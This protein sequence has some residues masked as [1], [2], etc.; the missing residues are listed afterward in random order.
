MR[1]RAEA[2]YGAM[3]RTVQRFL[4]A[5]LKN[6][7]AALRL[8]DADLAPNA[9]PPGLVSFAVRRAA[10]PA[11]TMDTFLDQLGRQGFERIGAI[12]DQLHAQNPELSLDPLQVHDWGM[13]LLRE[14]RPREAAQVFA[15][16]V[17]LYPER[18]EFLYDGLGQAQEAAG[19]RAGAIASYRQALALEPAHLHARA[20]LGA[21]EA[22]PAMQ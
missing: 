22:A 17:R 3:A 12:Y 9:T 18:F 14:R 6:D 7:A 10:S 16:G 2:A 1:A 5:R 19:E 4:D 13:K 8:L 15:L 21:L 11:P 20:R